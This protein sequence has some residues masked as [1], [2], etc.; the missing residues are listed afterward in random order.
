MKV[1]QDIKKSA[2]LNRNQL[3]VLFWKLQVKPLLSSHGKSK[4]LNIKSSLP[5]VEIIGRDSLIQ[6]A[7][8]KDTSSRSSRS[9]SHNLD[10]KILPIKLALAF[11]T[12]TLHKI[13]SPDGCL[14]LIT[15]CEAKA[16]PQFNR[17]YNPCL[18]TKLIICTVNP[19]SKCN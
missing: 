11:E 10:C 14:A 4:N 15:H 1:R 5:S 13:L 2:L 7:S 6:T 9:L 19:E 3:L 17:G 8:T 16:V 18:M 12:H